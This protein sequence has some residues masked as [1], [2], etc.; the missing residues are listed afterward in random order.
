V[1]H[2]HVQA[3]CA[4]LASSHAGVESARW[5]FYPAPSIHVE[6]AKSTHANG[7]DQGAVLRPVDELMHIS[8]TNGDLTIEVK[9]NPVDIRASSRTILQYP[10]KLFQRLSA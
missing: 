7:G 1:S 10:I 2:T 4:L 6:S 8:P 9:I 3:K 5:P